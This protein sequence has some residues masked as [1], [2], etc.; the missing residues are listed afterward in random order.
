MTPAPTP[1]AEPGQPA[2]PA[3]PGPVWTPLTRAAAVDRA[4]GLAWL[5][6]LGHN[7]AAPA[8]LLL[9]LLDAGEHHFLDRDDLPDGVLDAAIAHPDRRVRMGAAES[10]RLSPAQWERLIAATPGAA[11]REL[12]AELAEGPGRPRNHPRF[13][14][15]GLLR[16]AADPNPRLRALALDDPAA[17]AAH[18]ER[19]AADPDPAVRRAAAAD[20]RLAPATAAVLAADPDSGVRHFARVNP[21]LPPEDLVV[22]L[23]DPRRA[24]TAARNPAIPAAVLHRM[25]DLAIPH[26]AVPRR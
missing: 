22:L 11:L 20:R 21:A 8:G 3:E 5:S 7:R 17:T 24:D 18:V 16:L 2:E 13:P 10:G 26:A 19:A 1:P 15:Q 14:R 25:A 6:G 4:T 23:L 9:R 12:F